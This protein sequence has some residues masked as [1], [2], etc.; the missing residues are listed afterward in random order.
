MMAVA[1]LVACSSES[2]PGVEY[3]PV[4]SDDLKNTESS[5]NT[6]GKV[7]VNVLI[8]ANSFSISQATRGT[9]PFTIPDGT[10]DYITEHYQQAFFHIFAFR[11]RRDEQGN[12]AITPDY[13]KRSGDENDT[14][15]DCLIDGISSI[16]GM[17]AKLDPDGD[18]KLQQQPGRML[19]PGLNVLL[20]ALLVEGGHGGENVCR[21]MN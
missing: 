6:N 18:L 15:G 1:C 7:P 13:T 19:L 21:W 3:E 10:D 5:M 9:G 4:M 12:D 14:H 2:Y 16:E 17:A 11:D 20:G 8:G